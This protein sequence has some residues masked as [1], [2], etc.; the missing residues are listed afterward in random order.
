[1]KKDY[2]KLPKPPNA[3][4]QSSQHTFASIAREKCLAWKHKNKKK[5]MKNVCRDKLTFVTFD[6]ILCKYCRI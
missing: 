2:T 6:G 1:M 4:I 5:S 3:P